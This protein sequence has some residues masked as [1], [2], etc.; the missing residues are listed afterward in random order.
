MEREL[1]VRRDD[2]RRARTFASLVLKFV[3]IVLGRGL[4]ALCVGVQSV[5]VWLALDGIVPANWGGDGTGAVPVAPSIVPMQVALVVFA[6][7]L[8]G[9]MVARCFDGRSKWRRGMDRL[10]QEQA[11]LLRTY[12]REDSGMMYKRLVEWMWRDNGPPIYW[13][14]GRS[15]WNCR[16][17]VQTSRVL[18]AT[19][20]WATVAAW[21]AALLVLSRDILRDAEGG[22]WFECLVVVAVAL[23]CATVLF[24]CV[25][26]YGRQGAALHASRRSKLKAICVLLLV[27]TWLQVW[28]WDA[29]LRGPRPDKVP[30]AQRAAIPYFVAMSGI[31]CGLVHD[32]WLVYVREMMDMRDMPWRFQRVRRRRLMIATGVAFFAFACTIMPM[33]AALEIVDG[34][35]TPDE[36]DDDWE[37]AEHPFL[38]GM[39]GAWVPM[40]FFTIAVA[41]HSCSRWSNYHDQTA[42]ANFGYWEGWTHEL[43]EVGDSGR[44]GWEAGAILEPIEEIV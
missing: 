10:Q 33:M 35:A 1:N 29:Y 23:S 4:F 15:V 8:L 41:L 5:L 31:L 12:D 26:L 44:V 6:M 27:C 11:T 43:V 22:E 30:L 14:R 34:T 2:V 42:W 20:V 38:I 36:P 17:A 37:P 24:T 40:G 9:T 3:T 32:Q 18:R 39:M 25:Q 28:T 21:Q 19:F 16:V 13:R 7:A